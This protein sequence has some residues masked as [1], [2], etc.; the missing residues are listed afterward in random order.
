MLEWDPAKARELARAFTA[1]Y[2]TLPN[3]TNNLRTLSFGDEDLTG[4]GDRLVGAVVC[5]GTWTPSLPTS[6]STMWPGP[7][8]S[9]VQVLS[10]RDSFPLPGTG[11]LPLPCWPCEQ[12]VA[13][14]CKRTTSLC[15]GP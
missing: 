12:P 6:E 13:G 1:G 7:V 9:G 4:G 10:T 11:S 2:L 5:W 14:G 15:V 8:T 3:Y